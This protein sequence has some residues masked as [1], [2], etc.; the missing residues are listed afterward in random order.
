MDT[1]SRN[2]IINNTLDRIYSLIKKKEYS[3]AEKELDKLKLIQGPNKREY[4]TAMDYY[5]RKRMLDE[6]NNQR[7]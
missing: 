7:K 6:A 5:N 3:E 4:I 1:E 2:D